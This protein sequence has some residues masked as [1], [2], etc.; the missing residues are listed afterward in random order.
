MTSTSYGAVI[1]ATLYYGRMDQLTTSLS[2]INAGDSSYNVTN[3]SPSIAYYFY[4]YVTYQ[5]GFNLTSNNISGTTSDDTTIRIGTITMNSIKINYVLPLSPSPTAATLYYGTSNPPT[6]PVQDVDIHDT[7]YNVTGLS[8]SPYYFYI[9]VSF[10]TP[11]SSSQYSRSNQISQSKPISNII[12]VATISNTSI[13]I[14]YTSL[15]SYGTTS[16]ATLYY[17]TSS[18]PTTYYPIDTIDSSYNFTGLSPLSTYYYYINVTYGSGVDTFNLI[19]NGISATTVDNTGISFGTIKSNSIQINYSLPSGISSATLYYGTNN[20][21]TTQQPITSANGSYN[22]PGSPSTAYYYYINAQ[23][24]SSQY[25]RTD[26][27]SQTTPP[28]DII[29][30]ASISNTSVTVNYTE[31][32]SY[33]T[34]IGR[35]LYHGTSS[36]PTAYY[37]IDTADSSYNFNSLLSSITYYYYINFTY[38]EGF[39]L[40]SNEISGTTMGDTDI[41]FGT[42]TSNS[43]KI[44]Y[45]LPS[46]SQFSSAT[47]YYGTS[48]PP[49]IS[50]PITV[51]DN[52]YSVTDL[53]PSTPY[54]YYMDVSF[55]SLV[56]SRYSRSNAISQTTP[57]SDMIRIARISNTFITVNYTLLAASYGDFTGATLYY[58]T[59]YPPT[60]QRS[61]TSTTDNSYSFTGF[62]TPNTYYYYMNFNYG[63]GVNRINLTS[64][65]I[66][67]TNT[68][69][70][71]ISFAS[72]TSNSIRINYRLPLTPS[73]ISSAIL[74]YGTTSP[75]TGT[76]NIIITD[77]GYVLFSINNFYI[78]R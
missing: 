51:A 36:Q 26:I 66:T 74:Y 56:Y 31:L 12:S 16:A 70:T 60:S 77:S 75:P 23:Y 39:N 64:N 44:N 32:T 71:D 46:P 57:I 1:N 68:G 59:S 41:S 27:F 42:I 29:R 43:M 30:I 67:A 63:S 2:T 13:K 73:P 20:P 24:S 52:S 69:N 10:S 34:I 11:Y 54:Y 45:R 53:F 25:S 3:L 21:P 50:L 14:N 18:Q 49:T 38:A 8:S 33:G 28:S 35:N 6:T 9:D 22:V 55:S 19:S 37:S 7:S 58:G 48:N 76:Q 65:N 5:Y 62:T 61:I 40:T 72:I 17:G 15:T 47:L 78:W 4:I